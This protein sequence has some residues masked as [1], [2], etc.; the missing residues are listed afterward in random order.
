MRSCRNWWSGATQQTLLRVSDSGN[1]IAQDGLLTAES[2]WGYSGLGDSGLWG[3]LPSE[4]GKG[5]SSLVSGLLGPA[6]PTPLHPST[7]L[8]HALPK[9]LSNC[10]LLS[11]SHVARGFPS[12]S[13]DEASACNVGDLGS[14][15]GAGRFPGEG[16]GN[17][18]QYSCLKNPRDGGAW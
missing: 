13:D 1:T 9:L 4:D 10:S 6:S 12:G 8:P 14:T 16:N 3:F 5:K 18:P 11:P 2:W 15:P 17:P 7:S